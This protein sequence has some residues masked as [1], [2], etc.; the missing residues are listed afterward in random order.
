MAPASSFLIWLFAALS[1]LVAAAL[2]LGVYWA[3]L[4]LGTPR[5]AAMRAGAIAAILVTLWLGGTAA[6][7]SAGALHFDTLPPT[8]LVALLL[9][10]ALAA[11]IGLSRVGRRLA[12]GLPLAALVA[13]HAFRLPLELLMH[14]AYQE[15]VMPVQMSYSGW[16]FDIVTGV[17]AIL[18]A[19]LLLAGRMPLWGVRLWNVLGLV[20]L[21]NILII[22]MLSTPLPFRVFTS[23][24]ANVWITRAPFVWLPMVLVMTAMVGH[25]VLL[26]R[27]AEE[28][29]RV[30]GGT[31]VT[32]AV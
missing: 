11:W 25:V 12:L 18:V 4:R 21:A 22:A 32:S 10:W 13:I 29:R 3:E 24:P 16:N 1:I 9:M 14:R 23:E 7:A 19:G 31:L 28:A 15:G 8:M 27:L 6:A 17:T 30:R 2:P 5:A 20:L 26:R